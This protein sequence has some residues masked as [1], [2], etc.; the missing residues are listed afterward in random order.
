MVNLN[1]GEG[2]LVDG[3]TI[4]GGMGVKAKS[5]RVESFVIIIEVLINFKNGES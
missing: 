1:F 5:K 4:L 3:L 2:I